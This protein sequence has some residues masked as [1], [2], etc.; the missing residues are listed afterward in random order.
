MIRFRPYQTGMLRLAF[1]ATLLLLIVPTLGRLA[2]SRVGADGWESAGA[3]WTAICTVAGLKYVQLP[4]TDGGMDEAG[5]DMPGKPSGHAGADCDYCPL[6]ASLLFL[7]LCLGLFPPFKPQ[8]STG[9]I[10]AGLRREWR[11]P[12]GLGSRGPP[13]AL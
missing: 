13:L 3:H 2:E 8:V 5:A 6:L 11:H 4:G 7:A 12:C 10:G 1:L 9:R